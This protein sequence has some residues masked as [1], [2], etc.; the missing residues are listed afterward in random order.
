MQ[1]QGF[2]RHSLVF[3][4]TVF[5]FFLFRQSKLFTCTA[6]DVDVGG[7]WNDRDL[8]DGD[9]ANIVQIRV[10]E[11]LYSV[12]RVVKRLETT[13]LLTDGQTRLICH[14]DTGGVLKRTLTFQGDERLLEMHIGF[15]DVL[16]SVRFVTTLGTDTGSLG[17][18][19]GSRSLFRKTG[20]T[21]LALI[22]LLVLFF[23]VIIAWSW[24]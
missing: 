14:G 22:F 11:G 17:G 3:W 12:F 8:V 5:L 18:S 10:F 20:F 15:G 7:E 1:S 16:D 24:G 2:S 21:I 13:Y 4:K 19:G 23:S 6:C 9:I